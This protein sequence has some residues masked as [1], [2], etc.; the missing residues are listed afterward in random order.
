MKITFSQLLL[1]GLFAG[2]ANILGG[3]LLS[4]TPIS[5]RYKPFLKYILAL[6][7]GFMLA[8][9]SIFSYGKLGTL[10][11]VLGVPLTDAIYTMAR[12]FLLGKSPFVADRGHLHHKLLSI[13]WGRRRI[14]FFYW[15]IS[16]LF[17]II[18]LTLNSQQKLFAIILIVATI[19][20]FILWVS[21]LSHIR[22]WEEEI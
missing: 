12:R 19:S 6:G 4:S 1:L 7:A 15:F 17:G 3:L 21:V 9:I 8:V 22:K 10:L 11:L 13:G 5:T 14:A 2:A 16:L 20:G 18:A